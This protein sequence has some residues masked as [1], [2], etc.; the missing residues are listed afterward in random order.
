MRMTN[1]IK[2]AV[3]RVRGWSRMQKLLAALVV[4][5][6]VLVLVGQPGTHTAVQTKSPGPTAAIANFDEPS[7]VPDGDRDRQVDS[8]NTKEVAGIVANDEAQLELKSM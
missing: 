7:N 1:R 5:A 3:E 8:Y 6:A 2:L 4:L